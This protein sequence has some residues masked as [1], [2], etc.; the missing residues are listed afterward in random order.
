MSLYA[1]MVMWEWPGNDASKAVQLLRVVAKQTL[2]G[3]YQC[4]A[5]C[6]RCFTWWSNVTKLY[7]HLL[8]RMLRLCAYAAVVCVCESIGRL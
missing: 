7:I 5:Q 8:C 3:D 4:L 1:S 2:E 6:V